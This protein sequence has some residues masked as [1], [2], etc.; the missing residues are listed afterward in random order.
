[1]ERLFL[2]IKHN[3]GFIWRFI[4]E[5]NS[6]VFAILY[7]ARLRVVLREIMNELSNPAFT[8]RV[9]GLDDMDALYDLI[10][11]QED[12]DLRYFQPHGFERKQL[13][14]QYENRAFLMMGVFYDK[15]LVGYFFL[16]FFINRKCFVGRLIDKPMRG[17]GMGQV[18]NHIMYETAWRLGFRC[19]STISR[20]NTAVMRAHQKNQRMIILKELN[21]EYLLV[22]FVR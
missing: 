2:F 13:I 14:R 22:E 9:L 6:K 5:V 11:R 16:R 19:L 15:S 1:M 18:M 7:L 3:L 21:K 12:S 4:E 10:H 17:K 20:E 8:Y